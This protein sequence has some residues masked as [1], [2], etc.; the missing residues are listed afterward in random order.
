[1]QGGAGGAQRS[2]GRSPIVQ[3][4]AALVTMRR[5]WARVDAFQHY[6]S[7]FDA[8]PALA[9][10]ALAHTEVQLGFPLHALLR[11]SLLLRNGQ[12]ADLPLHRRMFGMRLLRAE[13]LPSACAG[14]QRSPAVAALRLAAQDQTDRSTGVGATSRPAAGE[15]PSVAVAGH[16]LHPDRLVP[17]TPV[18]P[19]Q[20]TVAVDCATGAVFSVQALVITYA[21]AQLGAY[22]LGAVS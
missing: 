2:A 10:S 5:V 18:E 15:V 19:A 17:I 11:A 20:R 9:P 1:V 4:A 21:A 6:N 7:I 22:L 8:G 12:P 16:A 13:E 3:L 14:L